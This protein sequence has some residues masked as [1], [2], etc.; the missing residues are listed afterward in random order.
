MPF[1]GDK[2]RPS[3]AREREV[4]KLIETARGERVSFGV[5]LPDQLA[6]GHVIAKNET[7]SN[8]AIGKAALIRTVGGYFNTEQIPRKDPEYRKGYYRLSALTPLVSGAN[9]FFESLAVA[10]EAIPDGKLGRVAVSGLVIATY[11][12]QDGYVYPN[13]ANSIA[14]GFFGLA[15]VVA[16]EPNSSFAVWDLSSRAMQAS[17]TL[18]SNWAAGAASGTIGGYATQIYDT[19]NIAT[20]QVNGDRGM[21][22]YTGGFWKV[23][24]PWCVGS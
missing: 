19:E 1:P 10:V 17:Y 22:V 20:W 7:G 13:A 14:G 11:S 15:K 4:T 9:P 12:I 16:T 6:P 8:L 24:N 2:F 3:A 21:A 5:P 18:T 23:I